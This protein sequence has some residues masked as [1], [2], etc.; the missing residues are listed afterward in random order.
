MNNSFFL[1]QKVLI[2]RGDK[3]DFQDHSLLKLHVLV[4]HYTFV[5]KQKQQY[6]IIQLEIL[7]KSIFSAR[8]FSPP[9]PATPTWQTRSDCE[10]C[11]STVVCN[12]VSMQKNIQI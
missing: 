8:F 11:R 10:E 9:I 7:N 3:A 2:D 1:R 6:C 12:R 5:Q 4:L